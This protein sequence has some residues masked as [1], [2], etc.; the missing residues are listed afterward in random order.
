MQSVKMQATNVRTTKTRKIT[1]LMSI[2]VF[3]PHIICCG[4]P[5]MFAFIA[6]GTTVGLGA[7]LASNPLY[8]FVNQ[9]HVPLL[10]FA[11]IAVV[12]SGV[13]N[14]FAYKIDCRKAENACTHESCKP[15]KLKSFRIFLI[16]LFLLFLDISWFIFETRF[17]DLGS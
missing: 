16:S 6:L 3:L 15:K 4:L 8:S 14:Y 11:T 2:V 9:Y 7:A 17:L 12:L 5:I 10:I 1:G 13:L